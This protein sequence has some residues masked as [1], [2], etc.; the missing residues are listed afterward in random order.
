MVYY[1]AKENTAEEIRNV[2]G[3]DASEGEIHTYFSAFL[4]YIKSAQFEDIIIETGNRVYVQKHFKLLDNYIQGLK[5]NY[6]GEIESID[7]WEALDAAKKINA[8]IETRTHGKIKDIF[9]AQSFTYRTFLV[10]VNAIYFK[11]K[12]EKPFEKYRTS[13][14]NFYSSPTS[15]RK[16]EM[17][18]MKETRL[19]Y[20]EDVDCQI[21]GLPYKNDQ[22]TMFILL[23]RKRYDIQRLISTINI[24]TFLEILSNMTTSEEV[25]VELPRF[26]IESSFNLA[27]ALQKLGISEAFTDYANFTGITVDEIIKISE[28]KHKAFIET[29]EEGSEAAAATVVSC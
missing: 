3:K 15:T 23:P 17:M 12:W 14:V 8:F 29:N 9:S 7:F 13:D 10:L 5:N 11:G 24:S 28:V 25:K 6:H 2:I 19:P 1:G 27:E 18:S 4:T 26:K 21:L 22:F 16:V 20:Y